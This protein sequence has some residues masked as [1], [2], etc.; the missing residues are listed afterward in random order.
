MYESR[1]KQYWQRN[2]RREWMPKQ[3]MLPINKQSV[4][5]DARNLLSISIDE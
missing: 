2:T 5:F 3:V 4:H 1:C